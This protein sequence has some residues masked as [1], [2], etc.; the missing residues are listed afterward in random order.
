MFTL[1]NTLGELKL[2]PSSLSELTSYWITLGLTHLD[3]EVSIYGIHFNY[4]WAKL[5]KTLALK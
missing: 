2:W 3:S 1:D 4:D 5:S